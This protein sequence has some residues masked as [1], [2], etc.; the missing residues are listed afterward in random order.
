M[1]S[2]AR[3]TVRS[4]APPTGLAGWFDARSALI[5]ATLL[6]VAVWFINADHGALGA[7]T[8]AAKQF[9]Y[10]FFMAGVI[11]RLCTHLAG[12]RGP[13]AA[14]LALATL[15][16]G[17]VTI[18]ATYLVHSLRGTPEP[19]LSTIPVALTSPIAFAV[20]SWRVRNDGVTPWDR[21]LG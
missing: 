4:A 14:M 2:S 21:L 5:G 10:T 11:M 17:A 1:S 7:S 19:A 16:P 18:G 9:A 8:A 20:W 15:V 6:S 3:T 12:R 13:D